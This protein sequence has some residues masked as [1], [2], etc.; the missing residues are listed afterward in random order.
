[1]ASKKQVVAK[2]Y[3][4]GDNR[5]RNIIRSSIAAMNELR[6]LMLLEL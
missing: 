1:V 2:K 5:E 4:F 3:L 6:K